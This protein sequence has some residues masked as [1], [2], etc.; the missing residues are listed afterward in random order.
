MK[1]DFTS[2]MDR[3]GKDA[4]AVDL[5]GKAPAGGFAPGGPKEG[6]DLIPMWVA[7]MNFPTVP[8]IIEEVKARLE[9]PRLDTLIHRMHISMPSSIGIRSAKAWKDLQGKISV[10]RTECLGDWY[11]H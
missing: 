5:P 11:P 7:D 8:S 1:Y 2:I 6:F 4:I 10:T 3:R 9:H